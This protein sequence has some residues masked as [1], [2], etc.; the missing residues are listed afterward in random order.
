ML[1]CQRQLFD[2]PNEIAFFNCSTMSPLLRTARAAGEGALKAKAEPWGLEPAA[3]FEESEKARG[4]F[5]ELIHTRADDIAFVPAV[6]YGMSIVTKNLPVECGQEILLLAEQ[7]PS[8]VYPWR[9]L[10]ARSGAEIVTVPRPIDGNWTAAVLEHIGP[11]TAAASLPHAHWTDAGLLDLVAIGAALREQGARLIVDATQSLGALPFDVRRVRPDF[12]VAAAYKW[13]LGPYSLG[14]LYVAP[15][16]QDGQPLEY[17][18]IN[19]LGSENFAALVDYQDDF[20][21]GARRFDVGE[22]SNLMLMPM[23]VA[24]LEQIHA[25]TVEAVQATLRNITDAI[26][27]EAQALG[28]QA[29]PCALRAA[30]FLGVRVPG[31]IPAGF[32]DR[33]KA[34]DIYLSQR[35][36]ALR[37]SPHLYNNDNDV[38]RLLEALGTLG[39]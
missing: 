12:L 14:F 39:L 19:R 10:A 8:N 33:L 7:F 1:A 5:A 9:E 15:E 35:G 34:Q 24:A 26:G 30:H 4:L 17:N 21:A 16:H 13:L 18:W 20:Q 3:F 25:W 22:H 32:N 36:D 29:A 28:L 37:I 38:E 6:S 11:R 23:M 2:I 27:G 31:G